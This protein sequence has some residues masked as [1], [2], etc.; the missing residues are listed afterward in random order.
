MGL[1]KAICQVG[2]QWQRFDNINLVCNV[3]SS[4]MQI[5]GYQVYD[6]NNWIS[7]FSVLSWAYY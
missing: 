2:P 6:S 7:D 3:C 4:T 1:L 5:Q